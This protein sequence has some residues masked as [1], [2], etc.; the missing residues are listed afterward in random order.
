MLCVCDGMAL[1]ENQ[2]HITRAWLMGGNKSVVYNTDLGEK[3]D[4]DRGVVYM[5]T[6]NG[7]TWIAL[8]EFVAK[9]CVLIDMC[10]TFIVSQILL[11]IHTSSKSFLT[12]Y[13]QNGKAFELTA[14]L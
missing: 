12:R 14:S 9:V 3:I 8:H 2:E 6:D 11:H 7:R 13:S 10:S 1:P 4:R 5:S